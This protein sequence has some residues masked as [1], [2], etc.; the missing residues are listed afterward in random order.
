MDYYS[1]KE[2]SNSDLSLMEKSINHYLTKKS[3]STPAMEFGKA[4]HSLIL[5]PQKFYAEN[6]VRNLDKRTK[7]YKSFVLENEGKNVISTTDWELLIEMEATI[8]VNPISSKL[9]NFTD[10][11]EVEKEIFFKFND[12]DFRSKID[13][14]NHTQR[15]FWD[16]KSSNDLGT[17]DN[18][19][20]LYYTVKNYKYNR[21]LQALFGVL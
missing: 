5:E 8:H 16:L 1:R 15:Y 2:L 17:Y 10:D 4:F 11:Y 14:V 19:S 13:Y 9:V 7:E 18:N 6:V 21:Q 12:L 3:E 20:Q